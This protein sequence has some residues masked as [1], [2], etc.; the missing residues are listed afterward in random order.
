[1]PIIAVKELDDLLQIQP[2]KEAYLR[3]LVFPMNSC[4][5]AAVISQAP[6]YQLEI[7][8]QQVGS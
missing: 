5:E 2:Y 4:W 1:M 3:S 7:D 8:G 6:H